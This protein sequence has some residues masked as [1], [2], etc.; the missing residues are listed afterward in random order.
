[1]TV[2]AEKDY[3]NFSDIMKKI[4][5]DCRIITDGE[6]KDGF[7]IVTENG[8]IIALV[9]K[10]SVDGEKISLN[11]KYIAPGF[12]DIHCHG[13]D[14]AEFIDGTAEAVIKVCNIHFSH[15]T[16]VMLPT[17][18]ASDTLTVIKA[19]EAIKQCAD[20]CSVVI[21]GV[22]LEGPYLSK[23]MCGGQNPD[24][25]KA[26]EKEE[27]TMLYDRF[28]SLIK[29]WTYA[30]ENDNGDFLEFLND[31][32]IV[33]SMGHSA[34]EYCHIKPAFDNGCRLVTHLY[35]C[36]STVIRKGGF[37]KL[38]VIESAFLLK[39]MYVEAIADGK[40][41]PPELLKMIVEIKGAERVCLITDA[42]RPGGL[43]EEL[44]GKEY[45]DCPVPFVIEDGVA[46]LIDRSAFAGS[47]ATADILLKTA[48]NVGISLADSVLMLTKTPARAIGLEDYGRI[49]EGYNA[50]FT[51]FDD[52]LNID[53]SF[54]RA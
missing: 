37:R 52:E 26:P 18:S 31:K 27:Y 50:V 30:T 48:V 12:I 54:V 49:A 35:S 39:D 19:F 23:E 40:H 15:G 44:D 32:G 14:G 8:K 33:P 41:L 47:I 46:K 11:G 2:T 16:R 38:G 51:V 45:N 34:A 13:G 4:I 9:L 6:I 3:Y 25:V 7:D 21:P 10:N 42:I 43:G 22:H 24:S 20:K 28:G 17:L 53:N 5:T 29:R 1:M 36:T